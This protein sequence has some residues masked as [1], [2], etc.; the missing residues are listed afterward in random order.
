VDVT[1]S[2]QL[3][4]TNPEYPGI[5]MLRICLIDI[6]RGVDTDKVTGESRRAMTL[7][8][9]FTRRAEVFHRSLYRAVISSGKSVK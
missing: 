9:G 3:S 7:F 6:I 2:L 8:T 1:G 5:N 4:S